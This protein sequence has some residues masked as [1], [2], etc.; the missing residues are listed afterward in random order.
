VTKDRFKDLKNATH[1]D[2]LFSS[3]KTPEIKVV[4][5]RMKRHGKILT[6]IENYHPSSYLV[7]LLKS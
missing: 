7:N 2:I 1:D 5:V 4:Q 3:T 6:L